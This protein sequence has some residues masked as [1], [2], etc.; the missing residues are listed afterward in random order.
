[1][2]S[3]VRICVL[4]VQSVRVRFGEDKVSLFWL[5]GFTIFRLRVVDRRVSEFGLWVYMYFGLGSS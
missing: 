1:M 4:F 3:G 2:T 5:V